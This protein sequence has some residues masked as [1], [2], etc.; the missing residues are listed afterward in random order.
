LYKLALSTLGTGNNISPPSDDDKSAIILGPRIGITVLFF[1]GFI[2]FCLVLNTFRVWA[3]VTVSVTNDT[4]VNLRSPDIGANLA[5]LGS[6]G[7]ADELTPPVTRRDLDDPGAKAQ[8]GKGRVGGLD[9]MQALASQNVIRESREQRN[10]EIIRGLEGKATGSVGS[11]PSALGLDLSP[12]AEN[13]PATLR[14]SPNV[15]LPTLTATPPRIT[16]S[17]LV[18]PHTIVTQPTPI[19]QGPISTFVSDRFDPATPLVGAAANV[20][21]KNQPPALPELGPVNSPPFTRYIQMLD[22]ED[23]LPDRRTPPSTFASEYATP[24]A[25][26]ASEFGTVNRGGMG[27]GQEP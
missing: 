19:T 1:I 25:E 8:P 15:L 5:H 6:G 27:I 10:E 22:L 12:P 16:A 9:G 18:V 20:D 2:Y 3:G 13:L 7:A 11:V 4:L 24:T 17:D 26:L 21:P 23:G 14:I